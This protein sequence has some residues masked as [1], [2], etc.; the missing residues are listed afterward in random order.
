MEITDWYLKS[1]EEW[2]RVGPVNGLITIAGL[3]AAVVVLGGLLALL[4]SGPQA[5]VAGVARGF[6]EAVLDVALLSP[7]RTWAIGLLTIK[8]S[9]RRKVVIVFAVFVLLLL[10][11]MWYLDPA[12]VDPAKLY[13]DTVLTATCY[14]VLLMVLFLSTLSL[15]TDIRSR[16]LHTVV[17]KPVRK[18]E[19]VLGRVL[20]FTIVGTVL[21]CLMGAISYVFVT[22]GLM[23]RHQIEP[24]DLELAEKTWSQSW[25]ASTPRPPLRL[26]TTRVHGHRHFIYIEPVTQPAE[27]GKVRSEYPAQGD[28]STEMEAGHWH[29]FQYQ[30]QR[31]ADGQVR[32]SYTVGREEGVFQARA[33]VFGTLRFKDR[34]GKDA[35]RGISV[36]DEWT[37]RSY[38]HGGTAAAAIWT[39]EGITEDNYPEHRYPHGLPVE[40]TISVFR[41]HKGDIEKGVLGSLSVCNPRT[42]ETVLVSMF[43]AKEF[44]V[45]TQFIPRKLRD[46]Q[47]RLRDLFSDLADQ[48][49]LEIWLRCE[50]PNQYYGVAQADLYIRAHDAPF[51]LNFAKGYFGIWLQMVVIIAFGVMFSTFLSGP[52]AMLAT[53][54]TLV[55]G[56]YAEEIGRVARHELYGGGPVEAFIRMVR[57]QNVTSEME[58]GLRTT[59]AQMSD[60]VLEFFLRIVAAMLPDLGKYHFAGYVAHGLNVSSDML[61]K[62]SV[63][64]LGFVVPLFVL[65]YVF[66]KNRELP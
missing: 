24:A 40:M 21:L 31:G 16:T 9:I 47:G 42:G 20:G 37:Y 52:I 18:S 27:Q 46:K 32:L 2:L 4:R 15:P 59:L 5:A 56:M 22:R 63:S 25:E 54:A 62:C 29:S 3:F 58:P 6:A 19:I 34:A 48:G 12:S 51:W 36:G 1:F 41:S 60:S 55:G 10:F 14:L 30:F 53:A 33:P 61:A 57:Q 35:D 28:L 45:D 38:I 39:F 13:L 8:E 50:D 26:R 49:R 65:G 44:A 23:H 7:R 64:V 66:L 17:T 43:P 11:G